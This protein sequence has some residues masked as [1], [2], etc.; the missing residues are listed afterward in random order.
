MFLLKQPTIWSVP[1]RI[2]M[3]NVAGASGVVRVVFKEIVP[4]DERK[5]R[6]DSVDTDTGGGARDL[7]LRPYGK[8]ADVFRRMFP[9]KREVAR[10]RGGQTR[11]VEVLVGRFYWKNAEGHVESDEATFETP[12]D[13]RADEG[14]IPVVYKYPP[15][16]AK[17][18]VGEGRLVLLL[19]QRRDGSVWPHFVS[20]LSLKSGAWEE[21]VASAILDC[22]N[23]KRGEARVARGFIDFGTGEHF[24]A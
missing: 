23:K 9:E 5:F 17:P 3:A 2:T 6:N 14:R 10:K 21:N 11:T 16:R 7:R 15:L 12:T 18:P 4:G 13:V 20:E 24:C 22:L 19:I 8:F 1:G